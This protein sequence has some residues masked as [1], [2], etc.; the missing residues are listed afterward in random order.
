YSSG[1]DANGKANW[2]KQNGTAATHVAAAGIT[3]STSY[4]F[5]PN[6]EGTG[7]VAFNPNWKFNDKGIL[8]FKARGKK[9]VVV[10]LSTEQSQTPAGGKI[11]KLAIGRGN[12]DYTSLL[13][14]SDYSISLGA[15]VPVGMTQPDWGDYWIQLNNNILSFGTGTTAGS[16]IKGSWT[17]AAD[18]Q[19]TPK[20]FGLG[21]W[22]Q[23]VEYSN[24]EITKQPEAKPSTDKTTTVLEYN[25]I[26]RIQSTFG[27]MVWTHPYYRDEKVKG[28]ANDSLE[29]LVNSADARATN[30]CD[31][32]M[33]KSADNASKTGPVNYGDKIEIYSLN[34]TSGDLAY[35]KTW[36]LNR[37]WVANGDSYWTSA[38][39]GEVLI[40]GPENPKF[41]DNLR[42][43]SI[44]SNSGKTGAINYNDEVRI[45]AS[46][47]NSTLSND[48]WIG[49]THPKWGANFKPIH[50]D[51]KTDKRAGMVNVRGIF[52]F[53]A[54]DQA[55]LN[56]PNGIAQKVL[57]EIG[58]IPS[59]SDFPADFVSIT[60]KEDLDNVT[61]GSK[62]GKLEI[63]ALDSND[64]PYRFNEFAGAPYTMPDATIDPW[65]LQTLKDESGKDIPG[66][67][68]IFAT[69]D[70]NLFGIR[71]D[72]KTAVK[73]D[74][75]KKQWS[76]LKV[77]N[78]TKIKLEN[79]T[80]SKGTEIFA[81]SEDDVI[82]KLEN[83]TWKKLTTG[84]SIA[85]GIGTDGKSIVI[86]IAKTGISYKFASNK[87]TPM[88]TE[89][90]SKITIGN[91]NYILGITLDDRLVK[92][93][94]K[95]KK[96][97]DIPGKKETKIP[98]ID[99][100]A[101]IPSGTTVALDK[102]GNTYHKGSDA[103]SLTAKGVEINKATTTTVTTA[104]AD[105][106]VKTATTKKTVKTVSKKAA[107]KT[108]KKAAKKKLKKTIVKKTATTS[109]KRTSAKTTTPVKAKTASTTT[110]KSTATK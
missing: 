38:R 41:K 29:L 86:G 98:S 105:K 56:D 96:W 15:N 9:E 76:P 71:S 92:W 49:D 37:K 28:T 75:T 62:D 108:V 55:K 66:L 101:A 91:Q 63:W 23:Q 31:F 43:F 1:L 70:G 16:N 36:P 106:K 45:V 97:M 4:T 57:A 78:A 69:C 94:S 2:K 33:L 77:T 26:V 80:A 72:D 44:V 67:E 64:K 5:N 90:L 7:K 17:I 20:F 8:K 19:I 32:F 46:L 82:Y 10:V 14:N 74:F 39:H 83:N 54:P 59:P 30:G 11:Y 22:D 48:L 42:I 68:D 34:T 25:K 65:E 50:I 85:A 88:G 61:V 3:S 95:T 81:S 27:G 60:P 89:Q 51:D 79:I 104:V 13:G 18:K 102:F 103:V 24:I 93:D 109:T 110:T 87:W 21:G 6:V 47:P 100:V 53:L 73:Y 107:K 99:D 58:D 35:N 40:V 12:N 52:K 84:S